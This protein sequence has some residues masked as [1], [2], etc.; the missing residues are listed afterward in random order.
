MKQIEDWGF[1][2]IISVMVACASIL[3]A[4]FEKIEK[5]ILARRFV[6]K[7]LKCNIYYSPIVRRLIP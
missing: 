6:I 5:Q 3:I 1:F 2:L 7:K 4:L